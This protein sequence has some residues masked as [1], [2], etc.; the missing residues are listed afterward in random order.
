MVEVRIGRNRCTA[1]SRAV[2]WLTIA[3]FAPTS[4]QEIAL[5]KAVALPYRLFALCENPAIDSPT[6]PSHHPAVHVTAQR[7]GLLLFCA[8]SSPLSLPLR[9]STLGATRSQQSESVTWSAEAH[10]HM[11]YDKHPM[12]CA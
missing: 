9:S 4:N 11:L 5:H 6:G 1:E 10:S 2:T 12:S 7:E 8:P 3:T